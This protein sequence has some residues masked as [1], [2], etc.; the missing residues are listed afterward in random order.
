[1]VC[2]AAGLALV[3]AGVGDKRLPR[4]GWV[5]GLCTGS[6]K[7]HAKVPACHM[8]GEAAGLPACSSKTRTL[9][10]RSKPLA[11]KP[12]LANTPRFHQPEGIRQRMNAKKET[13]APLGANT[14]QAVVAAGAGTATAVEAGAESPAKA[15][16]AENRNK[17]KNK[18]KKSKKK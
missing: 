13:K 3:G 8:V 14:E 10:G 16:K 17:G 4:R 9:S 5:E 7:Q 6:T 2:V 1:M 15:S 12:P 18:T 11:N